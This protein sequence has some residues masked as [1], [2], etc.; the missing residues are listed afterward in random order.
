MWMIGSLLIHI[1]H[2]ISCFFEGSMWIV[3]W[4]HF[5]FTIGCVVSLF[6]LT[7]IC[8][9]LRYMCQGHMPYVA[10]LTKVKNYSCI[11]S[12]ILILSKIDGVLPWSLLYLSTKFHE[13]CANTFPATLLTNKPDQKHN[14]L[15]GGN[16][17]ITLKS[18]VSF[19][20]IPKNVM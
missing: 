2:I 12:M 10:M 19:F 5:I 13:N 18:K 3:I 17:T 1:M 16:Q 20:E 14:F 6:N 4:S 7:T 8:R 11:H 9:I 15:R